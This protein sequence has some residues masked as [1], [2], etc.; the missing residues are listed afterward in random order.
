VRA[1]EAD[2]LIDRSLRSW[3]ANPLV[4]RL[5]PSKTTDELKRR[6]SHLSAQQKADLLDRAQELTWRWGE[7]FNLISASGRNRR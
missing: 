1:A 4:G 7:E 2:E 5:I 6:W 3:A